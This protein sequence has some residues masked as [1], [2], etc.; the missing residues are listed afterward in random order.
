MDLE[1][2]P[3]GHQAV[4]AWTTNRGP[5]RRRALTPPSLQNGEEKLYRDLQKQTSR[6]HT[7]TSN[8]E[9]KDEAA[10]LDHPFRRGEVRSDPDLLRLTKRGCN[11]GSLGYPTKPLLVGTPETLHTRVAPIRFTEIDENPEH[12]TKKR[13]LSHLAFLDVESNNLSGSFPL[14]LLNLTKLSILF[15]SNNRFSGNLPSSFNNTLDFSNTSPSSKLRELYIDNNNFIGPIPITI[16][17]SVSLVRV[18]LGNNHLSGKLSEI[19]FNGSNLRSL[20]LGHNQLVGKLPRSLSSCSSLE[21][22]NLEHNR[23]NDTFQ[24]WLESLR[25]LQVLVLHSNEFHG[26][27]QYHPNVTP[28]FSQLRII[29]ISHNSFTGT[30]PSNF[31]MYWSAIFSKGNHS[32]LNYIGDRSYDQDSLA[33]MNKGLK[34][35]YRRILTLLTAIDISE[36]RLQGNIPKSIGQVKNLIVLNLSSNGFSGH[37]PSSLANLTTLESLDLSNNKLSGQIPPSLGD[38]TSLSNITVSHN[39]LVGP[40]PQS[41]QF[42]TQD[43][44]SFEDNMGLC[45]RPLSITCG[46]ID[47]EISEEPETEEEKEEEEEKAVLSWTAAVIGLAPGVIFGLI[48]GTFVTL[49]KPQWLM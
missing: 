45:G 23:I 29:D 5:L 33:L 31:F 12:R 47:T 21:V 13:S 26:L 10:T 27:L 39:Q 11:R 32:E 42:Q 40:I 2:T 16:F 4:F 44:S 28:S 8:R 38:L 37:I 36:N 24:F 34:M 14:E 6:N 48:I 30:L 20:H 15:L 25:N 19:F 9:G 3:L 46:D 18:H 22:L 17:Q 1:E 49:Q 35:K 41:T 7:G 43:A